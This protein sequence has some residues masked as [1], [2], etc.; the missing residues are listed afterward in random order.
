MG[1]Y[2]RPVAI[3]LSNVTRT[4]VLS[5]FALFCILVRCTSIVFEVLNRRIELLSRADELHHLMIHY[6]P[7]FFTLRIEKLRK[8]H[9]EACQLVDHIN[10]NFGFLLLITITNGFVSFITTS[11]ELVRSFQVTYYIHYI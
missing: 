2:W 3:I 9:M 10:E 8:N 5:I 11:F 1:F 4:A 6:P 7:N